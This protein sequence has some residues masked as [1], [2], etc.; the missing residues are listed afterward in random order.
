[1]DKGAFMQ[2]LRMRLDQADWV[3]ESGAKTWINGATD[4]FGCYVF[5]PSWNPPGWRGYP[6][7]AVC[8]EIEGRRGN[9]N[10]VGVRMEIRRPRGAALRNLWPREDLGNSTGY[11]AVRRFH[12]DDFQPH[13]ADAELAR[14]CETM[15][16]SW[17]E[18]APKIDRIVGVG[19]VGDDVY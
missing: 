13:W 3:Y 4:F 6:C 2:G 7:V 1:M 10:Y 16:G 14:V 19:V 17:T 5:R 15:R 12:R 8:F 11:W 18:L 9:A